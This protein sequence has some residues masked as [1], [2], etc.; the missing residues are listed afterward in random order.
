M[1]K[2]ILDELQEKINFA[3]AKIA[4]MQRLNL[5]LL[6][7]NK[8]LSE[9]IAE[10]EREFDQLKS[11]LDSNQL[12]GHHDRLKKYQETEEKVRNKISEMLAKLDSLKTTKNG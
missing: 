11:R 3:I 6:Q 1:E 5:L 2:S 12:L 7:E 8:D 4:E 9:Q 10:R